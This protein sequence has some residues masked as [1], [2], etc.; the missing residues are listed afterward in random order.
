[1][2]D[3]KFMK[4]IRDGR[5]EEAITY[6]MSELEGLSMLEHAIQKL[7][8]G[9]CDPRDVEDKAGDLAEFDMTRAEIVFGKLFE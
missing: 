2:P 8:K 4:H 5:K 6:W 3:L 9:Q 7:V 1:M